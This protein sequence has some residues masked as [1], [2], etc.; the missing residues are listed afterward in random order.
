MYQAGSDVR[1]RVMPTNPFVPSRSIVPAEGAGTVRQGSS[2]AKVKPSIWQNPSSLT[3]LDKSTTGALS[4]A[5]LQQHYSA[6]FGIGNNNGGGYFLSSFPFSLPASSTSDPAW[7]TVRLVLYPNA[8][9]FTRTRT[10]IGR[11]TKKKSKVKKASTTQSAVGSAA[12][13][14][15]SD[16]TSTLSQ[17][18]AVPLHCLELLPPERVVDPVA[19]PTLAQRMGL[20]P[21]E[22][23]ALTE[24]EWQ[25]VKGKSTVSLRASL[26]PVLKRRGAAFRGANA[27]R[28]N[29]GPF[30]VLGSF[31]EKGIKNNRTALPVF[32][33]V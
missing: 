20:I 15:A 28:A 24:D 29:A 11:K 14:N 16:V 27:D 10:N 19:G 7:Y 5:A 25:H 18:G 8:M 33:V 9:C 13:S 3:R 22:V 32:V 23:A 12:A 2:R 21:Y 4:A 30:T 31:N 26:L 17:R 6:A 1:V